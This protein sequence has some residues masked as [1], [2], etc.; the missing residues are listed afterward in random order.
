MFIVCCVK[1]V[2][3]YDNYI[4]ISNQTNLILKPWKAR[5]Q[6]I[7]IISTFF[8]L[9]ALFLIETR[10]NRT[11]K[12]P[13]NVR[14]F[15]NICSALLYSCLIYVW[16]VEQGIKNDMAMHTGAK[17]VYLGSLITFLIEIVIARAYS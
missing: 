9:I 3:F 13:N 15:L 5:I 7:S 1:L 8:P 6:D 10:I 16:M 17:Y 11:L 2:Y 12:L 14:R 4:E